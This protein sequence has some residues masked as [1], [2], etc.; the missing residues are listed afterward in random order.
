LSSVEL[1]RYK[2]PFTNTSVCWSSVCLSV[3]LCLCLSVRLSVNT[4]FARKRGAEMSVILSDYTRYLNQIWYTTQ[5]TDIHHGGTCQTD[6]S[7]K[8]KMAVAAI[9]NFEKCQYLRTDHGQRLQDSFSL[10]VVDIVSNDYNFDNFILIIKF[11]NN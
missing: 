9:L 8:S 10:H 5:E 4:T 1:C 11:V 3:S 7:R 6:L 2:H